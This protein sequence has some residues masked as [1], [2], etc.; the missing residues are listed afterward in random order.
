MSTRH[1]AFDTRRDTYRTRE[2]KCHL[3]FVALDS[4]WEAK[5]AQ[6]LEDMDEVISYVK[7]QNLGFNIPYAHEGT[8]RA[9]LPDYIVRINDGKPDPLNLILEVTG[10]KRKEKVAKVDAAQTLWVPAINNDGGFGRWS[11]LEIT[12]PWNA[13][14]LIRDFI[15]KHDTVSAI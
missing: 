6:S 3:N 10:E 14:H 2:D 13:K 8:E 15:K 4:D 1:V 9:Y 12:D 5:L 7:N 11:F